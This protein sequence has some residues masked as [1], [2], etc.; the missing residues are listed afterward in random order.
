MTSPLMKPTLVGRDTLHELDQ[1]LKE[2]AYVSN[3]WGPLLVYERY[4]A[5]VTENHGEG[6]DS[7]AAPESD[8]QT[9]GNS[10][11]TA[12]RNPNSLYIAK[13]RPTFRRGARK[14]S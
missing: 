14:L 2:L 12:K 7:Q 5:L 10:Y 3:H 6:L 13:Q 4:R 11:D 1:P 9:E 8:T